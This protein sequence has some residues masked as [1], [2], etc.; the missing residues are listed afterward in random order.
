[1]V[2]DFHGKGMERLNVVG[3]FEADQNLQRGEGQ[4]LCGVN[5]GAAGG[6]PAS[7]GVNPTLTAEGLFP[8]P[9]KE[10]RTDAEDPHAVYANCP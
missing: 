5:N 2:G 6:V 7:R 3:L 4:R 1:M 10:R 9:R 8:G